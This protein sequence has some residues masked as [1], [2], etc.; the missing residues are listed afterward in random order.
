VIAFRAHGKQVRFLLPLPAR[1][2]PQ[3]TTYTRS[4]RTYAR[5]ATEAERL[6]EQAYRQRWRALALVIKAKLEAVEAGITEFQAE[7]L[8]HIVLPGG[9][10][11]GDWMRPQLEVTYATG[12]MPELLPMLPRSERP[13]L[14]EG[15]R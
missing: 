1:D 6:W 9:E 15:G 11:V 12:R 4:Y 13:T 3:F 5:S 8:A 14:P 10:T 2:E 7:F